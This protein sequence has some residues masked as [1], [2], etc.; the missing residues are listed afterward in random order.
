MTEK[1]AFQGELVAADADA[2]IF[3]TQNPGND[4]GLGEDVDVFLSSEGASE[5]ALLQ[6]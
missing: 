1:P 6:D 4:K 3:G 5:V 2:R